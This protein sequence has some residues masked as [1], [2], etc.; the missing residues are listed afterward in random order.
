M[1]TPQ[2]AGVAAL[3]VAHA[4]ASGK[5]LTPS[6]FRELLSKSASDLPPPGRD[7]ASG[8][9]LVRP[10]ELLAMIA[11]VVAPPPPTAPILIEFGLSDLTPSG[12]DK[13]RQLNPRLERITF[14]LKP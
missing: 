9:G 7:N 10:V 2:I 11:T 12:R 1:A 14:V 5:E 13:L 4:T 3:A 8:V 6:G